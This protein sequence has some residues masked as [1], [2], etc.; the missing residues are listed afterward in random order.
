MLLRRV[1]IKTDPALIRTP[2]HGIDNQVQ[3][4]LNDLIPVAR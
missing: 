3:Q 1:S 4:H 2:L